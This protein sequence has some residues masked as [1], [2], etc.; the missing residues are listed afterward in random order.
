VHT[1][2]IKRQKSSKNPEGTEKEANQ[3]FK[4]GKTGKASSSRAYNR[5]K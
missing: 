1:V 5:K 2:V 3:H 4:W